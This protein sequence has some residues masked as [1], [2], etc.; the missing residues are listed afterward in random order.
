MSIQ[1]DRATAQ[2]LRGLASAAGVVALLSL[3]TP[4]WVQWE[5]ASNGGRN[6]FGAGAED[7][8]QT[9]IHMAG[10]SPLDL[11][12]PVG[13]VVAVLL[14]VGALAVV[15]CLALAARGA[16]FSAAAAGIALLTL[17]ISVRLWSNIR[18]L[19][20]DEHHDVALAWGFDLWRVGLMLVVVTSAAAAYY[21]RDRGLLGPDEL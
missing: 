7:V 19:P 15:V 1:R 18:N 13:P 2:G 12:R 4:F 11:Y 8:V 5:K 20:G 16:V 21:G 3:W 9:G 6:R 14:V 10:K 17:V